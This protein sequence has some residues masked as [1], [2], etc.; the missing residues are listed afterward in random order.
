MYQ[1]ERLLKIL[2]YLKDHNSMSVH[3]ICEMLNVSRDTARR[4]II[5][6]IEQGAAIRTHGGISL[7]V[8]RSAIE[9]YRERMESF[10]QEKKNIAERAIEFID[11]G[12][13]YFFDVSTTVRFLAASLNKNITVF[14]HSLDNIEI[15]S[16]KDEV[17]VHSIGGC[18]NK[19]NRFFFNPGCTNYLEGIK[20]DVAFLGAAAITI[21]GLYY[22]DEEDAFIK[23]SAINQSHKI[24]LLADHQK[25]HRSS[26]YRGAKWGD[27]D[28]L[29][30]DK[31][32]PA[33]FLE[34]I[35]E[36]GIELII[37]S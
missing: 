9:A 22:E 35:E 26:Y 36:H 33:K 3:H 17:F 7:P 2:E 29:I 19:R 20:F 37:V 12:K 5:K 4:D 16:E 8:F 11:E 23:N 14:T 1:E 32:P 25:F 27:I 34:L 15:L 6:L 31:I 30:T 28:I 24:I 13:H 10:S 21:D 18:L